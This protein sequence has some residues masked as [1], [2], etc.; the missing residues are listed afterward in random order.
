MAQRLPRLRG[1]GTGQEDAARAGRHRH[2]HGPNHR[3]G[4]LPLVGV[5]PPRVLRERPESPGGP[6]SPHLSPVGQGT[7]FQGADQVASLLLVRRQLQRSPGQGKAFPGQTVHQAAV[8]GGV[9]QAR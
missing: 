7:G 4:V 6:R 2:I 8:S 9:E 3:A 5:H 1:G